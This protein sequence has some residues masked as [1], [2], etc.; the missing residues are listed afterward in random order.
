MSF[1]WLLKPLNSAVSRISG[2]NVSMKGLSVAPELY[3]TLRYNR[4]FPPGYSNLSI[5]RLYFSSDVATCTASCVPS[6]SQQIL[7]YRRS[8][9]SISSGAL[10]YTA[11]PRGLSESVALA[12]GT[13]KYPNNSLS[14]PARII[15]G[16]SSDH[17]STEFTLISL[18]RL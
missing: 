3:S 7:E 16:S 11:T 1:I 4:S 10:E 8:P 14:D 12:K 9:S 2:E 5:S 17:R 6:Y 13:R 18:P 15:S